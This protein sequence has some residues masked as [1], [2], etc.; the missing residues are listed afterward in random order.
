MVGSALAFI[1]AYALVLESGSWRHR[2]LTVL[3]ILLVLIGWRLIYQG[4][5]YGVA[6]AG[7]GI[8][9]VG[10]YIDPSQEP[11]RFAGQ[12]VPRMV[13]LAGG[14]LTGI[15][16]DALLLLNAPWQDGLMVFYL[17]FL[18]AG[19]IVILPLLRETPQARFW[20][21]VMVLALIPAATVTPLLHAARISYRNR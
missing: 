20:F 5:G 21:A 2:A 19:C 9:N 7:G 4:L 11:L 13:A 6:H 1:L 8:N 3:P 17:G 18:A 10:G 14:Q 15:P 16:P 12:L